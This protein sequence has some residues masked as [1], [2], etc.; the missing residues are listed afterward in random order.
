MPQKND[1]ASRLR[2]MADNFDANKVPPMGSPGT[3]TKQ[4]AHDADW[5][6]YWKQCAADCRAAAQAV[7]EWDRL[8]TERP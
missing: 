7:E 1:L 3:A 4:A 2:A 6:A 5:T 8:R